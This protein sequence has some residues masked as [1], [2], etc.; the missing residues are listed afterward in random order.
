MVPSHPAQRDVLVGDRP[1]E[2]HFHFGGR[3]VLRVALPLLL[4]LAPSSA[5]AAEDYAATAGLGMRLESADN[6]ADAD[7]GAAVAGGALGLLSTTPATR[8][9]QLALHASTAFDPEQRIGVRPRLGALLG[10][11]I[12]AT[13]SVD[14]RLDGF[15]DWRGAGGT[16]DLQAGAGGEDL[17]ARRVPTTTLGAT[18]S[19][20]VHALD[21]LRVRPDVSAGV[22][23]PSEPVAYGAR[24]ASVGGGVGTSWRF[25]ERTFGS[26]RPRI[27][28]VQG[29]RYAI[30]P[31]DPDLS[32]SGTLFGGDVALNHALT[33]RVNARLELGV[34]YADTGGDTIG[35]GGARP[36]ASGSIL[37]RTTP[38][39]EISLEV[40]RTTD[41]NPWRGAIY[42]TTGAD[43]N[44]KTDLGRRFWLT[45]DI[46]YERF[47]G[48][49][50][51]TALGTDIVAS[52]VLGVA[53][54]RY[55][56]A[57]TFDVYVEG[58]VDRRFKNQESNDAYRAVGSI[59]LELHFESG[60]R[61]RMANESVRRRLVMGS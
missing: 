35:S 30:R 17:R 4:L 15:A 16:A 61:A 31:G 37:W 59:G 42:D 49:P 36:V 47:E 24:V 8:T 9:L 28:Y 56:V 18:A 60:V 38:L 58:I 50:F 53:R 27:A 14:L 7:E 11:G 46:V 26:V 32:G 54:L 5:L 48:P 20:G 51:D 41:M 21:R 43:L 3:P 57:N 55:D 12:Q 52:R 19:V 44:V 22:R 13:P 23:L 10:G 25:T 2:G 39:G 33:E 6:V 34:T 40:R 45:G 1:K 29:L